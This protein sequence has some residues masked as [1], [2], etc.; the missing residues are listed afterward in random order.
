MVFWFS[1]VKDFIQWCLMTPT[2]QLLQILITKLSLI[3]FPKQ[4]SWYKALTANDLAYCNKTS[5]L[6]NWD[7]FWKEGDHIDLLWLMCTSRVYFSARLI[8]NF[9]LSWTYH[10]MA[11]KGLSMFYHSD[12]WWSM[13]Q[14]RCIQGD[15]YRLPWLQFHWW[16][17]LPFH[18]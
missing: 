13:N 9:C 10:N 5:Y 11:A 12:M 16:T 2:T 4:T 8:Q 18:C 3:F 17:E 15:M 7:R 1:L 6:L 14:L